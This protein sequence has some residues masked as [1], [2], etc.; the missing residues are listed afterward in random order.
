VGEVF[1]GPKSKYLGGEELRERQG[2]SRRGTLGT[3]FVFED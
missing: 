1:R 2:L 3:G